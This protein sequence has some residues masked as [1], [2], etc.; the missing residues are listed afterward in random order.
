MQKGEDVDTTE[1]DAKYK[2]L[3]QAEVDALPI[4]ST[5]CV[6]W[7]GGNGP[8]L[9]LITRKHGQYSH[10]DGLSSD[11]GTLQFVGK[12]KPFDIVWHVQLTD[13]EFESLFCLAFRKYSIP[14][15][16]KNFAPFVRAMKKINACTGPDIQVLVMRAY[17][18]VRKERRNAVTRQDLLREIADIGT[19]R[20]NKKIDL[21]IVAALESS[22]TSLRPPDW[23]KM[24]DEA[25]ARLARRA[26]KDSAT[27]NQEKR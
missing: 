10:I 24:I 14:T 20:D 25:R 11:S 9:Y 15:R 17:R 22:L 13:Q 5:V 7:S 21:A 18:F 27:D 6:L 2:R 19:W 23:R 1:L 4:G 3:S 26:E 16:V 8:H 12:S